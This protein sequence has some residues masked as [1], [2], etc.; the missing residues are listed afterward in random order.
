M[1]TTSAVAATR[2]GTSPRFSP[3]SALQEPLISTRSTD[4]F[5]VLRFKSV[6]FPVPRGRDACQHNLI[7]AFPDQERALRRYVR[8]M[9]RLADSI[10]LA[11]SSS[12]TSGQLSLLRKAGPYAAA[13]MLP[14][15][16]VVRL[17]GIT[18]AAAAVVCG[19]TPAYA[20]SARRA[21][22]LVQAG[23]LSI[24]VGGGA[25]FPRGGGQVLSS[26]MAD[27]VEANG[28]TIAIARS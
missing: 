11:T 28:G 13:G 4:G 7:H 23:Y 18:G 14:L 22:A 24:Y 20:S 16:A 3:A 2:Q 6:T 17:C 27:V 1:F 9:R 10:D 15:E 21:P 25:F 8:L 19:Q 12:S 5:D 26:S